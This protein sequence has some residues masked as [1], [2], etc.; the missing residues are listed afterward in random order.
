MESYKYTEPIFP[1][2][3]PVLRRC[4]A[5]APWFDPNIYIPSYDS[6]ILDE[7]NEK[8]SLDSSVIKKRKISLD[9]NLEILDESKKMKNH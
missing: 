9:D 8:D 2:P 3:I 6:E 1:I 4:I 7:K 5:V